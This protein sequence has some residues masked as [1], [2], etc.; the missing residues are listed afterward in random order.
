MAPH[1]HAWRGYP[2]KTN[3]NPISVVAKRLKTRF[4]SAPLSHAHP[5]KTNQPEPFKCRMGTKGLMA[6]AEVMPLVAGL[7]TLLDT[8]LGKHKKKRR[9]SKKEAVPHAGGR[10]NT[11]ST[12]LDHRPCPREETVT[13]EH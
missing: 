4:T 8:L 12:G 13:S 11:Y 9:K 6:G 1:L 7:G 10:S 5:K 3:F 2:S